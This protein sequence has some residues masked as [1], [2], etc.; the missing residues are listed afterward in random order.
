MPKSNGKVW[1]RLDSARQNQVLC[2]PVG[3]GPIVSDILPRLS[4]V[5]YWTLINA[6]SWYHSLKLDKFA[7]KCGRFRYTRLAFGDAMAGN[8]F[9]R[10]ISKNLQNVCGIADDILMVGYICRKENLKQKWYF[11]CTNIPFWW[12]V[13]NK[14]KLHPCQLQTQTEILVSKCKSFASIFSHSK[15]PQEVLNQN[16]SVWIINIPEISQ[17]RMD[18]AQDIP[19]TI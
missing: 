4:S 11:R 19:G 17:S 7:Y 10:K 15:L 18:M 9:Q 5:R 3:M 12:N 16:R 13:R 1:L 6:N 14:E 8:M 2:W